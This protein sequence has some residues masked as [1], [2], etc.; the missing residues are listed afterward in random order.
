MIKKK[1]IPVFFV[2]VALCLFLINSCNDK[3]NPVT[4]PDEEYQFDSARYNWTIDTIEGYFSPISLSCVDTND[5]YFLDAYRTL[6]HFNGK[7]LIT[8]I[9]PFLVLGTCVKAYTD[10]VY[11]GGSYLS[12]SNYNLPALLVKEGN[13]FRQIQLP[14]SNQTYRI[15]SIE[16]I[17]DNTLWFG[18]DNGKLIKYE[19]EVFQYFQFDSIYY[20]QVFKDNYDNV[21]TIN[22]IELSD[23][24]GNHGSKYL[25]IYKLVNNNF[26][27]LY[28]KYFEQIDDNT[29]TTSVIEGDIY[30]RNTFGILKFNGSDFGNIIKY[31]NI[32]T[33]LI[34]SGSGENDILLEG[35]FLP[36]N[37]NSNLFHW[38]GTKW[39]NELQFFLSGIFGRSQKIKGRY[40]FVGPDDPIETYLI[41]GSLKK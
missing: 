34:F 7:D 28:S 13:N 4:M 12:S 32:G 15:I 31:P 21:F 19:S 16:K 6:I 23:S 38:D 27:C 18:T 29:L 41:I 5:I 20:V 25:Q 37:G 30:A 2:A 8:H 10:E 26:I 14:D 17:N 3:E 9:L 33:S 40:V 36:Y 1:S 11:I 24:I 35:L 39:S 22:S